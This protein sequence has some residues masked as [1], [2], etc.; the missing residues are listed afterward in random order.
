MEPHAFVKEVY[1]RMTLRHAA[2]QPPISWAEM[3][4]QSQVLQAVHELRAYCRK[5]R[6]QPSSTSASDAG[7][8]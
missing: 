2:S 1:R 7:G 4:K 8:F 5:T 6:T 3:E